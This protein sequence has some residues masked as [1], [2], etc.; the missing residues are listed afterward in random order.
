MPISLKETE[1]LT[2]TQ[3]PSSV[4]ESIAENLIDFKLSLIFF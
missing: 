2:G 4:I 3:M 1:N